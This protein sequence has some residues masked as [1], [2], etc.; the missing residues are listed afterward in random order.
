MFLIYIHNFSYFIFIYSILYHI[1]HSNDDSNSL[2]GEIKEENLE[3]PPPPIFNPLALHLHGKIY[4]FIPF[5]AML[6]V[7]FKTFS[8][9]IDHIIKIKN[10]HYEV[11]EIFIFTILNMN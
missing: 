7:L 3:T 8:P 6:K 1:N 10:F 4:L 5:L 9:I 2:N 11:G